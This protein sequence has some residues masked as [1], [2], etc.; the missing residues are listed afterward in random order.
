MT[1][2]D[3]PIILDEDGWESIHFLVRTK[4]ITTDQ[5]LGVVRSQ[6]ASLVYAS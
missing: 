1:H 2:A 4:Q 3:Y 6:A 5:F